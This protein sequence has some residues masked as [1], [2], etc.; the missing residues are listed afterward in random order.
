M[1]DVPTTK[2]VDLVFVE[3]SYSSLKGLLY[4]SILCDSNFKFWFSAECLWLLNESV[5]FSLE[6]LLEKVSARVLAM[7]GTDVISWPL[8]ER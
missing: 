3:T 5:K 7:S 4:V 6:E 1:L 8:M 2:S